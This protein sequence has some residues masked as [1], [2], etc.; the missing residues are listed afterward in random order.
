MDNKELYSE[1]ESLIIM[2]NID[3]TKTAGVLTRQI[4]ELIKKEESK[5]NVRRIMELIKKEESKRK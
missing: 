1:I 3:G 4:M 5:R 2:W